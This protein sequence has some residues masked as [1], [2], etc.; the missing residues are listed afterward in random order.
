MQQ[1]GLIIYVHQNYQIHA[2]D[3]IRAL[4]EISQ[5]L[6]KVEKIE[7]GTTTPM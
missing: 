7:Q 5:P 2:N 3:L 6:K 4:F 1:Y